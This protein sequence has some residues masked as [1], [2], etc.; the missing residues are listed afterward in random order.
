MLLA[1]LQ[2]LQSGQGR[3]GESGTCTRGCDGELLG[4]LLANL[5]GARASVLGLCAGLGSMCSFFQSS[6]GILF[7]LID[8]L[9]LDPNKY[10]QYVISNNVDSS[11]LPP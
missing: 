3:C 2:G 8:Y 9:L 5:E 7:W 6:V 11:C 4:S 10:Y 1:L